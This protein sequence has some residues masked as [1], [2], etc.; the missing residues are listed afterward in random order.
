MPKLRA[1]FV[2]L[3]S[4]G[5]RHLRNL[6]EI[7]PDIEVFALRSGNRPLN[8]EISALLSGELFGINELC[9]EYDLCFITGPTHLHRIAIEDTLPFVKSY[10]VEKPIFEQPHDLS[11]LS[12]KT[13]YVAAPLRHTTLF[14]TLQRLL[15]EEKPLAVRAICSSY[16]PSWRAGVDYRK[17][18]SAI[19]E[20]GGGVRLD[21][22]H[23]W[24]YLGALFG[25]VDSLKSLYGNLSDLEIDSEDYSLYI[26]TAN[27]VALSVHLDYFGRE[28]KRVCEIICRDGNITADFGSGLIRHHQK[29]EIDCR[30]DGNDKYIREMRHFIDVSN[31]GENINDMRRA[32]DTLRLCLSD[33]Y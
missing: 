10:F 27:G 15:R 21:L 8:S 2:G 16:L 32:L 24:D 22:I 23:E 26:A 20:Q 29:G 25:S 3:G 11:F 18:Y 14:L 19:K 28:Y 1:L 6:K 5:C 9:G 31:G 33:D 30:E 7:L 4:I 13:V 12:K 17:C